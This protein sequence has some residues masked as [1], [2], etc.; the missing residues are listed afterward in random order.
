M[1][2]EL[3][4]RKK[5]AVSLLAVLMAAGLLLDGCGKGAGNGAGAGIR[6]DESE[7]NDAEQTG[8]PVTISFWFPWGGDFEKEFYDNVVGPFEESNPDIK[9][10]MTFV[11]NSDNSQASDKLLTAIAGGGAP[12]VAMFDR[13]LVS[14][15]ASM[16]ALED[17][18]AEAEADGMADI[19]YPSVWSETQYEGKTFALPWNIDSRAMFYNKTLM[20]EAGL[21]PE[22]PPTTIDELDRMAERMFKRNGKGGYDQVGLIPWQSQGFLYTYGWNFG[23]EWERN[24]ELT[25]ND[26]ANVQ[27]LRWMQGYAKKYDA[28]KLASFSDAL[29]QTGTNPFMSGKVGFAMEGNWLLNGI[30]SAG[31]EWGVMPMPTIDG[32]SSESWSG[33]WSFVMPKGAKHRE[34][35]WRFMK[36]IAGKE[37]S[38]LWAG[39]SA[40]KND[41]TCIPELNARLGLDRKE[42]L[43]VFVKLLESAHMRPV[44][45]VGGYMWDEMYRV[46]NL[47]VRLQGEPKALLD[48]MKKNVDAELAKAKA[49]MPGGKKAKP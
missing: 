14:E 16:D 23:G 30:E 28:R 32:H 10:Q 45:P 36:F 47:A 27:A 46:Q 13:F 7:D 25:P 37:G 3:S 19:Y 6:E 33:G 17:L 1:L 39:R 31:F 9:V 38:L 35:A 20:K 34:Q 44:S 5:A 12:D 11:E 40:G 42:Y 21:D 4:M 48:E 2:K 18:T 41:L 29:R 49:R 8:D 24:G 26:P 43:S 22:K 15:W